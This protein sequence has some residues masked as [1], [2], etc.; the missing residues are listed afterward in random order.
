MARYSEIGSEFWLAHDLT[1][2][3]DFRPLWTDWLG[4]K[5]F[6]LSGRTALDAV[7]RDIKLNRT[8]KS[9]YLPSYCC[10]SIIK[11]FVK[12]E[13]AVC[14][15]SIGFNGG[16]LE[17][18]FDENHN[19]DIVFLME[20]FG[21]NCSQISE[22]AKIENKAI[23]IQDATHSLLQNEPYCGMVDYCFASFRKWAAIPGAAVAL[24]LNSFFSQEQDE[25]L[26]NGYIDLRKHA[27][28]LKADYIFAEEQ[29]NI[30][31]KENFISMFNIAEE[32][33]EEDYCGYTADEYS[34][35]CAKHISS[36]SIKKRRL[37]NSQMLLK[38]FKNINFI[39]PLFKEI[40]SDDCPLF[41]PIIVKNDN[42]DNLRKYLVSKNIYCPV[43]WPLSKY[44][45]KISS[46][47]LFLYNSELSLI[48]DQRYG[49]SDM[50]QI[51]REIK[52]FSK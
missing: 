40:K 27:M 19:C 23:V 49:I 5:K 31:Q 43:H 13:I 18:D 4:D 2:N 11:P 45:E 29:Y 51:V 46:Q 41:V 34:K 37:E 14:F 21:Y 38:E 52:N 22:I 20:Y 39:E 48:C 3:S 24:K 1:K 33:L 26:N 42:R 10:D 32:L 6:F 28:E 15:Y 36:S 35:Q 17:L 50:I 25:K 30:S 7:I 12:N 16:K 8:V 47:S 44:H 9:A